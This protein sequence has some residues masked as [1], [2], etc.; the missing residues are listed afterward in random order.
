M[1]ASPGYPRDFFNRLLDHLVALV[2]R[3]L[4]YYT[5]CSYSRPRN[6]SYCGM[7][8]ATSVHRDAA[9]M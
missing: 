7:G 2:A 3:P 8:F 1:Q 4:A 9:V 5:H 6:N